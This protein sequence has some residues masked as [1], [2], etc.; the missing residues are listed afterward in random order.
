MSKILSPSLSIEQIQRKFFINN[1]L[2][3]E[4]Q[5]KSFIEDFLPSFDYYTDIKIL[6]NSSYTNYFQ[7]NSNPY[8]LSKLSLDKFKNLSTNNSQIVKKNNKNED[9]NKNLDDKKIKYKKIDMKKNQS[10]INKNKLK[11]REKTEEDV[12]IKNI[13]F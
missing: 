7:S 8:G 9:E 13:N 2:N 6:T 3:N 5:Q 11:Q 10:Y 12:E 1:S 4:E